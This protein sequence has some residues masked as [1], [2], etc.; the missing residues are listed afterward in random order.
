MDCGSASICACHRRMRS[1]C[2]GC[3]PPPARSCGRVLG[4]H[5]PHNT[6]HTS[7]SPTWDSSGRADFDRA[8][9]EAG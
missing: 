2:K 5:A 8:L 6:S 9:A 7:A 4:V 3:M 1:R